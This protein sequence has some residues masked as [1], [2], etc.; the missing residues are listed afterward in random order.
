ML[1][2][3]IFRLAKRLDGS[4]SAS[5]SIYLKRAW[6]DAIKK[7]SN[8]LLSDRFNEYL[9]KS[10][11]CPPITQ[12]TTTTISADLQSATE[13][14]FFDKLLSTINSALLAED[15][16]AAVT[17]LDKQCLHQMPQLSH[18]QL[19]NVIKAFHQTLFH[20]FT[21]LGCYVPAMQRICDTYESHQPPVDFVHICY[22]LGAAKKNGTCPQLLD[23]FVQ[24]H[25][26]KY[27]SRV[28]RLD[29]AIVAAAAYRTAVPLQLHQVKRIEQEILAMEPE[30]TVDWP[31]LN[32]FIKTLRL[33]QYPAERVQRRLIDW[34]A[35]GRLD[36]IEFRGLAHLFVYF[37]DNRVRDAAAMEWFC[38][39]AMRKIEEA[40]QALRA[41]DCRLLLWC[42]A[43][44]NLQELMDERE[45]KLLSATVMS[46]LRNGEF[47]SD[48][49]LVDLT[50]SLWQLG[51]AN[52][53]LFRAVFKNHSPEAPPSQRNRVK[54]DGRKNLLLFC[55]ELE[56]PEWLDA[57]C[58][59]RTREH[60]W[61]PDRGSSKKFLKHSVEL[62]RVH[63]ALCRLIGSDRVRL[64]CPIR[65]LN[66]PGILVKFGTDAVRFVE[67]LE[68]HT[69]LSDGTTA[70]GVMQLKLNILRK[71][72][73][74][75]DVVS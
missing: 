30:P 13:N 8:D 66:I 51:F 34:M 29:L 2:R 36:A 23:K 27:L 35:C 75:V 9:L 3:S 54:L 58:M 55:I 28:T 65:N 41:K 24:R 42:L 26:N 60:V 12:S 31:L 45:M 40:H 52:E 70:F 20:R 17:A 74:A 14:R 39:Q 38:R 22:Y 10:T 64:V 69:V 11:I 46:Q 67:V 37:A 57:L 21:Q 72:G 43:H 19:L 59:A 73:C 32:V 62:S 6:I 68:R 5:R 50:M 1:P 44:L 18:R 61:H 25:F 47:K 48:D 33:S 56:H 4:T 63:E 15:P 7:P 53:Q 49:D 71:L 16:S